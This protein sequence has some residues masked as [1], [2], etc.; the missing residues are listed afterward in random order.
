VSELVIRLPGEPIPQNQGK[1]GRWRSNDGREGTT[2]RQPTKVRHY[3]LDLQEAMYRAAV[4]AGLPHTAERTFF[5]DQPL[6]LSIVAV[7]S[8]P[9]SDYKK[10]RPAPRRPHT[11][12]K[13]LDN[14]IKPVGDAGQGVLW[15]NDGQICK[16]YEPFEK[17][18]GAQGEPPYIEIRVIPLAELL[19]NP[20][21]QPALFEEKT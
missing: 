2:I 20:P 13:D 4:A 1:A 7:F 17:L 9:R 18:I 3:K 5:G 16:Y 21:A 11:G 15:D 19:T 6:A 14:L 12:L 10:T 8:C